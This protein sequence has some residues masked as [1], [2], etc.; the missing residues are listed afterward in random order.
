MEVPRLRGR[1][2]ATAAGLHHSQSNEGSELRLRPTLQLMA[3]P[4]PG[5]TEQGQGSNMH[6]YGY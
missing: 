3:M 1:I 2:R 6:P 5:P 4:D